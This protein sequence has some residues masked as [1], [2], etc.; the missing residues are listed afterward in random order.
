MIKVII[1]AFMK[2]PLMF[3]GLSVL[4]INLFEVIARSIDNIGYHIFHPLRTIRF[5]EVRDFLSENIIT[6]SLVII[7]LIIIYLTFNNKA[8]VWKKLCNLWVLDV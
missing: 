1:T 2:L 7:L 8:K 6:I 3:K 5:Q 4:F